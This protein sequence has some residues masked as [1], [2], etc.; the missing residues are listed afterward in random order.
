MRSDERLRRW[1]LLACAVLLVL[2]V[3]PYAP[4]LAPHRW[5]NP[6]RLW[7]IAL[8]ALGEGILFLKAAGRQAL[9]R[10]LRQ[11]VAL[12]GTALVLVAVSDVLVIL[13][14][15]PTTGPALSHVNDVLEFGYN[16]AGLA[17]LFWIPLAPNS[18][19]GRWLVAVDITIAVSGMALVLFVTT[20]LVGLA[21][22][23]AS[24]QSRIIQYGIVNAGNFVALNLLLVRGPAQPVRKAILFLASSVVLETVYWVI[25][26]LNLAG[27][28]PDMRLLDVV[29]AIDQVCY[30]NAAL[31]FL[32]APLSERREPLLPE[33]ARAVNPLPAIAVAAAGGLLVFEIVSGHTRGSTVLTLGVVA[34]SQL[35]VVRVLIA[36]HDRATLVRHEHEL[37][38]R[39]LGDRVHALRHLAGGIAHEFNNLMTVVVGNSELALERAAQDAQLASDLQEIHRAGERAS[40]LTSRLL[41]YAGGRP[42]RR[43]PLDLSRVLIELRPLVQD[44]VG[45]GVAV[46]YDLQ[47]DTRLVLANRSQVEQAVLHLAA[48]AR[49]AMAGAGRLTV[50]LHEEA[51]GAPLM[52]TILPMPSGP[53]AVVTVADEGM[54]MDAQTIER[55]FD[56]F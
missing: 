19:Y 2:A 56:P 46:E 20:T 41:T 48:N 24:E 9:Q 10:R 7:C 54:G 42:A 22:A 31:V 16:F 6:W 11:S 51:S 23:Q 39:L 47:R 34:L 1:T 29:F 13:M 26:Q 25:V 33:W 27:F 12:L 17:A 36:S 5:P 32:S 4:P 49:T 21:A 44:A 14:R 37:A 55:A 50:G 15:L 30:A 45:S 28:R 40:T 38:Q 35:L 43:E 52:G 18:P 8:V 3:A 53:Q